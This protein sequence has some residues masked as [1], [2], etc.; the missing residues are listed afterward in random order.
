MAGG[1]IRLLLEDVL[2]L[3]RLLRVLEL[4]DLLPLS[5]IRDLLGLL[6]TD[7]APCPVGSHGRVEQGARLP[8][9]GGQ[10]ER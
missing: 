5:R 10:E 4:P 6:L 9:P 7:N 3:G 8:D 1:E 2:V